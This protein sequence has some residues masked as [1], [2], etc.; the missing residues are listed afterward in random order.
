[1]EMNN[2]KRAEA[3]DYINN[4]LRDKGFREDLATIV[5]KKEC[6]AKDDFFVQLLIMDISGKTGYLFK[7]EEFREEIR[8]KLGLKKNKEEQEPEIE[9]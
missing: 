9:K 6:D 8:N 5:T 7:E 4:M 1:M 3:N 2:K